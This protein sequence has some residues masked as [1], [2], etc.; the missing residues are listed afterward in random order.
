MATPM[1]SIIFQKLLSSMCCA[2]A[3]Y[4][5]IPFV[6][7]CCEDSAIHKELKQQDM[8]LSLLSPQLGGGEVAGTLCFGYC[9]GKTQWDVCALSVRMCVLS[10]F[11]QGPALMHISQTECSEKLISSQPSFIAFKGPDETQNLWMSSPQVGQLLG[12]G[13]GL[14]GG[15]TG[16]DEAWEHQLKAEIPSW[17][18]QETTAA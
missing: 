12:Q 4:L 18:C 14:C 11:P 7:S 13:A 9:K 5:F 1:S 17:L 10:S 3:P 8:P 2:F 15:V 6:G 16:V